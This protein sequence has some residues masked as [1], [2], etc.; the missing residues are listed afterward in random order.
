[1]FIATKEEKEKEN[2]G[3]GCLSTICY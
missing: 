3:R 1:V 2:R